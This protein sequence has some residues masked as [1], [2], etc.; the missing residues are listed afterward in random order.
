MLKKTTYTIAKKNVTDQYIDFELEFTDTDYVSFSFVYRIGATGDWYH[1]AIIEC[2]QIATV[3]GNILSNVSLSSGKC[4]IRWFYTLSDVEYNDQIE[5]QIRPEP[6][7]KAYASQGDY[8]EKILLDTNGISSLDVLYGERHS[9]GVYLVGTTLY[10]NGAVVSS[11][12]SNPSH[13]DVFY[14]DELIHILIID[15]GF[16][17]IME[18]KTDGTLVSEFSVSNL[19]YATYD[20]VTGRV[21]VVAGTDVYEIEWTDVLT[22]L[23]SVDIGVS[24]WSY[25]TDFPLDP[26]SSPISATYGY[27][28]NVVIVDG[29]NVIVVDR[30]S[31]SLT[32]YDG[33][34]FRKSTGSE[35]DNT[36][37]P[38]NINV[39]FEIDDG[40]L[41]VF[42]SSGQQ[43]S[44]SNTPA[45]NVAYD[46]A[47]R[48]NSSSQHHSALE[49]CVYVPV[50]PSLLDSV[51]V[52]IK[53]LNSTELRESVQIAYLNT[54][55]TTPIL[56][57]I[58]SDVARGDVLRDKPFWGVEE[59][60]NR[61]SGIQ[62]LVCFVGQTFNVSI[63]YNGERVG[64]KKH[65]D[66]ID[67]V[68][69]M[70]TISVDLIDTFS[71]SVTSC[72][73]E[74]V[75]DEDLDFSITIPF[76]DSDTYSR[77]ISYGAHN[78]FLLKIN[79]QESY[80]ED[81]D[82]ETS[83]YIPRTY[84]FFVPVYAY[85]W[86]QILKE[87]Q[88]SQSPVNNF[89]FVLEDYSETPSMFFSTWTDYPDFRRTVG[90][91]TLT[92][93]SAQKEKII[94]DN[95]FGLLSFYTGMSPGDSPMGH[96][97]GLDPASYVIPKNDIS[98]NLHHTDLNTYEADS[99]LPG[100]NAAYQSFNVFPS[101]PGAGYSSTQFVKDPIPVLFT[102]GEYFS[103][104]WGEN[105]MILLPSI[106]NLNNV[107]I[108]VPLGRVSTT[109]YIDEPDLCVDSIMIRGKYINSERIRAGDPYV[110]VGFTTSSSG[111]QSCKVGASV[112]DSPFVTFEDPSGDMRQYTFVTPASIAVDSIVEA[113]VELVDSYS[114][115]FVF[116][117][118]KKVF[119]RY[120]STSIN[121]LFI[122]IDRTGKR[123]LVD[124]DLFSR[125][126]FAPYNMD[127][128]IDVGDGFE[129]VSTACYGD[130]GNILSGIS[131]RI[132]FNY[133]EELTAEE[134]ITRLSM[135]L[136]FTSLV[137]E[138][139]SHDREMNFS[140]RMVDLWDYPIDEELAV[141]VTSDSN[142]DRPT[143][144]VST[145]KIYDP[146][147]IFR[148]T[149]IFDPS[150]V[151][152]EFSSSSSSMS[153][154]SSSS[155]CSCSSSGVAVSSSS[156]S[157]VSLSSSSGEIGYVI[158]GAGISAVNGTY[159][160]DGLYG[161][162]YDFR[163]LGSPYYRLRYDGNFF[164]WTIQHVT[165][166]SPP[167]VTYYYV[168]SDTGVT[169][170][171]TGWNVGPSG[172]FPNPYLS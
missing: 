126:G 118:V 171:L 22:G 23:S 95:A 85:W 170:P 168:N 155:S 32:E 4:Q 12:F 55:R 57:D 59:A 41:I 30:D 110:T 7:V 153:S 162:H 97:F 48:E 17:K 130:I 154:S 143:K 86:R 61:G 94:F 27:S 107:D 141:F 8:S 84:S 113:F 80:Y 140:V 96:T 14:I 67:A 137:S 156:C 18:F 21:L 106:D 16:D 69:V 10:Y 142:T 158:S 125:Y 100:L 122:S 20:N 163:M 74:H 37:T 52:T 60:Y 169:P 112:D 116:Y 91:V 152:Y 115:N 151:A 167:V 66:G 103:G 160:Y 49:N 123:L 133:G 44:Y 109:F 9:D 124:Y 135:K 89:S 2:T 93:T 71:G 101:Y 75:L 136:L 83:V 63:P 129:S 148:S 150:S 5:V 73:S 134:Q 127:L 82:F 58:D 29:G 36:Y 40:K 45:N 24:V 98:T 72:Q 51:N 15:T 88:A 166:D 56:Q 146:D 144:R 139:T 54:G 120:R 64:Y 77:S 132:I 31:V 138:D 62:T 161:G 34:V 149:L 11:V 1:D 25:T 105:G 19:E 119:E 47:L 68:Y 147:D 39:A 6:F 53:C 117:A 43:L 50:V 131:K 38:F 78:L 92:L 35:V 165:T 157:A 87:I 46:R 76:A 79:V 28:N 111:I 121:N 70:E 164:N 114:H 159:Y 102:D 13:I 108:T 65:E 42:E 128:L 26:L 99:G 3:S 172:T 104:E 90:D 33:F 145:T 81:N